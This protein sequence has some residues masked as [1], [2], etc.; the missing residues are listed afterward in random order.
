MNRVATFDRSGYLQTVDPLVRALEGLGLF[1]EQRLVVDDHAYEVDFAS[2]DRRVIVEVKRTGGGL[3]DVHAAAL[4]VAMYASALGAE[5]GI[6]LLCGSRVSAAGLRDEWQKLL[7][8]LAPDVAS[9]LGLVAILDGDV[10]VE[11]DDPLLRDI[12]E[13][14][15]NTG[16][17]SAPTLRGNRSFEVM[18]VLL[19]R[20]LLHRGCI[21]VGEL[22]R[23]T[24]LSH[25]SV[26]KALAALGPAVQRRRDR[27]VAL[28]A[29]P[30]EA[31]AQ[32]V[33]LAP[34]VRQT[35]AFVDES[36]R[37]GDPQR[38][39][40]RVRRTSPPGVAVAGV[41]AARHWHSG[42]DLE[43]LPRLDL[44]V[45]APNGGMDTAF[46]ARLDPALVPAPPGTP[47]LLVLHAVPRAESLF[48][49]GDGG[50]AWAD[51]VEALLD[52]YELRLIE[53]ADDLVRALRRTP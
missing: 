18:R 46:V 24:G 33:A 17:P 35:S 13:A 23:Q 41:V 52:L 20:W 22:Q 36:G 12:A 49:V 50:P 11:P 16:G 51:P 32:L 10:L 47:P 26:S 42:L 37:G 14:A 44:S 25:P 27:S 4:Q 21:A 38:L 5:R 45:H 29:F 1:S 53:Q 40:D 34:K 3:R 8:V 15:A 28:C 48:V 6:V 30:G 31:W 43:G 39:L 19:S 2:G 9:R 7:K